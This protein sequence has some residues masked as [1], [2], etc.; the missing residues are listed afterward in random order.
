MGKHG[1]FKSLWLSPYMIEDVEVAN[2]F[3]LSHLDGEKMP[4]PLNG[5]ALKFFYQGN[6]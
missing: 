2:S 3:Y 4:F 6:I 5:K 1:K